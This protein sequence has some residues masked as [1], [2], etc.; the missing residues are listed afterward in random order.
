MRNNRAKHLKSTT[1]LL[2]IINY[3]LLLYITLYLCY[4]VTLENSVNIVT[5]SL[6]KFLSCKKLYNDNI[7]DTDTVL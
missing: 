2:I 5:L 3:F 7:I 4:Y 6:R 1:V